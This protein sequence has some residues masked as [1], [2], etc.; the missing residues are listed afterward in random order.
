MALNRTEAL[1]LPYPSPPTRGYHLVTWLLAAKT[2]A[3]T[4]ETT[5][6]MA[7]FSR[8]RASTTTMS[9]L[10]LGQSLMN[11]SVPAFYTHRQRDLEWRRDGGR[12]M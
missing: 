4:S 10:V 7:S 1:I 12:T 6:T 3:R 2:S 11:L 9:T 5:P 8:S